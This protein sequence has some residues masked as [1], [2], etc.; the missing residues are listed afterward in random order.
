MT[1]SPTI[2]S[3]IWR[4]PIRR[5]CGRSRTPYGSP[6]WNVSSGIVRPPPLSCPRTSGRHH[7]WRVGIYGISRAR[8]GPGRRRRRGGPAGAP[9]GASTVAR[10]APRT[11]WPRSG[12]SGP[13]AGRRPDLRHPGQPVRPP[14]RHHP[15]WA[16]KN[17]VELCF[18]PTYASWAN[19]IDAHFGPL[20]Q[21]TIANS[22]HR[23]HT[24][25]TRALHTCLRWRNPNAR[26]P[27]VRAAQRRERAC[28][29][30]VR[31]SSSDSTA[32]SRSRAAVVSGS[33][34][35]QGQDGNAPCRCPRRRARTP[36][37]EPPRRRH[38]RSA[39]PRRRSRRTLRSA[40]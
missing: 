33:P 39:A 15:P 10:R 32:R 8:A 40:F 35:F 9:C 1:C 5:P 2:A 17:K 3:A 38:D 36:S 14:G 20:R 13:L 31:D 6:S 18:T 23:N 21:F 24:A 4:S 34:R 19:P 29:R 11:P 16:K 25:Q 28:S 30:S 37:P 7:R 22:N 26:H 12:R 27:D